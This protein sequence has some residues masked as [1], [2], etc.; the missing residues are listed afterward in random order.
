M[1]IF[2]IKSQSVFENLH[3]F[4]LFYFF[5]EV[6]VTEFSVLKEHPNYGINIVMV[7]LTI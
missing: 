2:N 6:K 3:L 5:N 1:E 7:S 4:E